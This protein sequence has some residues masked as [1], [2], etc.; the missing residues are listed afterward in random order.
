MRILVFQHIAVE[1]PGSFRE[2]MA[3]DGI[4]WDT[5]AL[6][7]GAAIPCLEDYAALLVMGGPMDV[8]EE[9]RYPWLAAEK[10]AIRRWIDLGRP[11]LGVCLATSC[12]P[13]RSAAALVRCRHRKWALP[14]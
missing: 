9:D 7:E 1:H 4:A 6:D 5:V 12:S 3:A 11:F 2:M 8:W 10:Q 13:R 14:T